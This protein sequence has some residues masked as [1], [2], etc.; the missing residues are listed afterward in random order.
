MREHRYEGDI[1]EQIVRGATRYYIPR[2]RKAKTQSRFN[3]WNALVFIV[4]SMLVLG[5]GKQLWKWLSPF[6]GG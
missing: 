1:G 2:E 6:I 5:I 3:A 4:A